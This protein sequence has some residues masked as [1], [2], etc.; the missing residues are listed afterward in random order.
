MVSEEIE[1][2]TVYRVQWR[3]DEEES[4]AES[5]VTWSNAEFARLEAVVEHAAY[6]TRIVRETTTV[7]VLG[8]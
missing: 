2:Y 4:W 6:Q 8:E 1:T 3:I 5:S 7:V